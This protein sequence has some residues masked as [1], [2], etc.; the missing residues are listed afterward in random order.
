MYDILVIGSI[1]ADLVFQTDRRP[2]VGETVLGNSFI[3][4]PGGKGA[5]QAVAAARLGA[6]VGFIGCVGDDANGR[7]M[8][9][10]LQGQGVDIQGISILKGMSTGVAGIV[11]SGGENSIIV[12]PGANHLVTKEIIDEHID[13]ISS[14]RMVVL[15]FEIPVETVEYVLDLCSNKNVPVILNPAP[16][17]DMVTHSILK[18]TYI[19]PNETELIHLFGNREVEDI[20]KEYS[21]KLV[22][23]QGK[24][25]ASFHN[26][27]KLIHV[28]GRPVK[29]VDTTGAGDTFNGA[30]AVALAEGNE[31][32]KAVEFANKAAAISVTKLGAQG[33]MPGREELNNS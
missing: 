15:Q 13:L 18:A 3:T 12:I 33:G 2:E 21:N 26:G 10:N 8:L 5:N 20:L 9:E 28:E 4:V 11:L 22:L 27:E 32:I 25:G 29:A 6:K 23:T 7:V 31:L 1:N 30:L 24:K 16:A 14:S 17:V 19:T